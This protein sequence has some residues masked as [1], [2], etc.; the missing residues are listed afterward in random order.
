[1]WRGLPR[2]SWPPPAFPDRGPQ[3]GIPN[4]APAASS[5]P[6][7]AASVFPALPHIV[8]TT[9][10]TFVSCC[11]PDSG[12]ILRDACSLDGA[13]RIRFNYQTIVSIC[14][15][16]EHPTAPPPALTHWYPHI[17]RL[18]RKSLRSAGFQACQ[19]ADFPA[20]LACAVE[21]A[22]VWKTVI[23]QTWKSAQARDSNKSTVARQDLPGAGPVTRTKPPPHR[24]SSR[25]LSSWPSLARHAL[26]KP[27]S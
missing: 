22:R 23:Q 20:G 11:M 16:G 13:P 7:L 24:E 25:G 6:G 21:C 1:M 5:P 2:E 12:A 19:V 8:V 3:P 15:W 18:D 17:F 9:S 14:L 26:S 4:H 10:S 27:D